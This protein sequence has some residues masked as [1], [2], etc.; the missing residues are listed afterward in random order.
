[1]VLET[2]ILAAVPPSPLSRL[3]RK[4]VVR[5]AAGPRISFA[6]STTFSPMALP[7]SPAIFSASLPPKCPELNP[8]ENIWQF[9]RDNWLSN[10]VFQSYGNILDHCCYSCNMLVSQPWTIMSIGMRDWAHRF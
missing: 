8:V 9:M 5:S 7:A 3:I 6:A 10:R 1:M 2:A 4:S